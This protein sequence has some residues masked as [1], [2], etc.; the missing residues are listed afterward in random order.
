MVPF[1]V[2]AHNY[3]YRTSHTM[4]IW[5]LQIYMVSES[6]N[7]QKAYLFSEVKKWFWLTEKPISGLREL[8]NP[9]L[10]IAEIEW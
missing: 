5:N 4:C 6:L 7:I 10:T 3:E 9:D 2:Y 1:H 8:G